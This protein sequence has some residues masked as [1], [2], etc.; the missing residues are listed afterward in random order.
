[1]TAPSRKAWQRVIDAMA[2]NQWRDSRELRRRSGLC[3]GTIMG[4]LPQILR[5]GYAQRI[6]N[7][8]FDPWTP[9]GRQSECRWLWRATAAGRQATVLSW[10]RFSERRSRAKRPAALSRGCSRRAF[11]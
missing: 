2:E 8:E 1:M 7:P 5:A 9:A 4:F 3:K 6:E 11:G 10:G